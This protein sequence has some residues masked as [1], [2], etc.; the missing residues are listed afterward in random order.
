MPDRFN[1]AAAITTSWK[2]QM[3]TNLVKLRYLDPPVFLDVAQ[4]VT[5]YTMQGAV[6]ISAPDWKGNPAGPAAGVSGYWAESPTIT[7]NLMTGDKF[8]RSLLEPASPISLMQLVESGWPVDSVLGVG[9]RAVNGL[10]AASGSETFR[11]QGDPRFYEL[12]KLLREL[13]LRNA[14]STRV[15]TGKGTEK[16]AE[17]ELLVFRARHPDPETQ[18][19]AKTVRELLGLNENATEFQMGFGSMNSNDT[20]IAFLTRSMLDILTETAAG[21]EIPAADLDEG[22]VTKPLV[23]KTGSEPNLQFLVRVRSSAHKPDTK[24]AFATI[25]YRGYWFWIDDRDIH[26]KRGL[27]FLMT[28]FTLASPG[29]SIAPPV[30]TI[31]K[32]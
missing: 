21:V 2:E 27:A 17:E 11:H 30:L 15:Q 8:I 32:P 10:Y 28:L 3:L 31:S 1:Y 26:S 4:I 16:G 12:L 29:A 20:E 19:M 25:Q 5:Q 13:Q 18:A 6:S 14:F 7:Y 9:V 23:V 24:E 22:R